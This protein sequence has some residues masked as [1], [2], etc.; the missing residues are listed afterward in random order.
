MRPCSVALVLTLVLTMV[1]PHLAT[2]QGPLRLLA[3]R[4]VEPDPT[5]QPVVQFARETFPPFTETGLFLTQGSELMFIERGQ[6]T[7]FSEQGGEEVQQ[8]GFSLLAAPDSKLYARND[9]DAE[10]S[11]LWLRLIEPFPRWSAIS[12]AALTSMVAGAAPLAY[13]PLTIEFESPS[14]DGEAHLFISELDL[15]PGGSVPEDIAQLMETGR[16]AVVVEAG[17]VDIV[18]ADGS[19]LPV[20]QGQWTALDGGEPFQLASAGPGLAEGYVTGLVAAADSGWINQEVIGS[21]CPR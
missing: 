6:F 13:Q 9:E 10:A 2:A 12:A 11:L 21:A 1:A 19:S 17:Q 18:F 7:V 4:S 5:T 15:E 8:S 3:C 16:V 14:I 20:P